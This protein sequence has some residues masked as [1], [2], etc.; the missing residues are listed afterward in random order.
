M[1]KKQT[2][3]VRAR[4]PPTRAELDDQWER[5]VERARELSYSAVAGGLRFEPEEL[6]ELLF[7]VL[8]QDEGERQSLIR[9][10]AEETYPE[11][12]EGSG[13]IAR[14]IEQAQKKAGAR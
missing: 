5:D 8:R 9:R 1:A 10:I 4:K 2:T 13:A 11:G 3:G 12:I 14:A 6:L 7:I